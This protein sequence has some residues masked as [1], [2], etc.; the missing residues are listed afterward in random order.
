MRLLGCTFSQKGLSYEMPT[1]FLSIQKK[2]SHVLQ[3]A[4]VIFSK[5]KRKGT[6]FATKCFSKS[7]LCFCTFCSSS[8]SI[9]SSHSAP[10]P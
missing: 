5:S 8:R 10:L 2:E 3:N 9:F 4:P 6:S 1:I 7:I